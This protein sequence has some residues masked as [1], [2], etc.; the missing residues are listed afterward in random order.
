[1]STPPSSDTGERLLKFEI[2]RQPDDVT[3]GPTCLHAIYR[4]FNDE[5]PFDQ[6]LSEVQALEMGGTLGVILAAHAMARGYK[7]TILTWNLAI[8]D[9]SWFALPAGE[10]QKRLRE[11]AAIK[12]DPKLRYASHMYAEFLDKGGKIE[13]HDLRPALL[14]KFLKK[15]LPILTGL[16]ATFL[17]RDM[18]EI[19]E[20]NQPDD[21]YG[22]PVGHFTVLTGYE[23]GRREVYVT[24]PMHPNPL[25]LTHTYPV[26]IERVVGAIYLGVL[27][28]DANL[29][30]LQPPS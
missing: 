24:D 21:V 9:P 4:Y 20:T 17:Y 10:M 2:Q 23:P 11:R 5:L 19:G 15:R 16:S 26:S 30:V 18:R 7:A 12:E 29:V 28:Y 22:D 27:T 3:C 14:R 13:L 1:M 8:F 25:S 6:V